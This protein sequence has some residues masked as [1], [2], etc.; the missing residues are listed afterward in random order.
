MGRVTTINSALCWSLMPFGGLL[1]GFLS[2]GFG[3]VA[4]LLAV[5]FAYFAATMLPLAIPS[6]RQFDMSGARVE[7]RRPEPSV[8]GTG[9]A[10]RDPV[11]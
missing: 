2:D 1:G 8:R 3:I 7:E 11:S 4:A 6:F 10:S 9:D 5:G